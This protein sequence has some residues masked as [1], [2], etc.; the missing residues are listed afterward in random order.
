MRPCFER[1]SVVI[2]DARAW[3]VIRCDQKRTL[4]FQALF[5]AARRPRE[6]SMRLLGTAIWPLDEKRGSSDLREIEERQERSAF[7]CTKG[8]G[9]ERGGEADLS[10]RPRARRNPERRAC[11]AEPTVRWF[12][13][14]GICAR[15]GGCSRLHLLTVAV[16]HGADRM[17]RTARNFY[18]QSAIIHW[19]GRRVHKKRYSG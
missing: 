13:E 12:K 16:L 6:C 5:H 15:G 3:R 17:H 19:S 11:G 1:P 4:N 14:K 18:E 7:A 8:G 2:R 9:T 10:L